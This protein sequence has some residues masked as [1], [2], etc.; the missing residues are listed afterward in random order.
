MGRE[1]TSLARLSTPCRG[2]DGDPCDTVGLESSRVVHR[3]LGVVLPAGH[4]AAEQDVVRLRTLDGC[5]LVIFPREMAPQLYDH[6]LEACRDNGFLPSAIRHA[7]NP[8]FVH[9]LVWRACARSAT[10]DIRRPERVPV[11][12][13]SNRQES[14]PLERSWR[15]SRRRDHHTGPTWGSVRGDGT[16]GG[17]HWGNHAHRRDAARARTAGAGR[18]PR[19]RSP[20]SH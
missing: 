9:G 4:P 3:P 1:K 19:E 10:P 7:R 12:T 8:H 6:V 16:G 5:S 14:N 18:G 20:R 11:R 15:P 17:A 13:R 2:N